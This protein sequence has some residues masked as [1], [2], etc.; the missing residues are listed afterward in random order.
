MPESRS[1]AE[2][3]VRVVVDWFGGV[4]SPRVPAEFS[5]SIRLPRGLRP[6][7]CG[8]VGLGLF[9]GAQGRWEGL[10]ARPGLEASQVWKLSSGTWLRIW[11]RSGTPQAWAEDP[12][13][14]TP[15]ARWGRS[16][17]SAAKIEE[18]RAGARSRV[19]VRAGPWPPRP[20]QESAERVRAARP[21][22]HRPPRRWREWAAGHPVLQAQGQGVG[23]PTAGVLWTRTGD[24]RTLDSAGAEGKAMGWN[25]AER[26]SGTYPGTLRISQRGRARTRPWLSFAVVRRVQP[27]GVRPGYEAKKARHDRAARPGLGPWVGAQVAS[28]RGPILRPGSCRG[29]GTTATGPCRGGVSRTHDGAEDPPENCGPGSGARS[30]ILATGRMVDAV[31]GWTYAVIE[32]SCN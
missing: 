19:G 22:A 10:W 18:L 12:D 21:Q 24:P 8:C 4:S 28:P 6:P 13:A 20:I 26:S 15:W 14:A 27:C 1:E 32:S 30:R 25:W 31:W 17:W 2:D 3:R 5:M 11:K 16:L 23:V 9:S 29:A 7:Q